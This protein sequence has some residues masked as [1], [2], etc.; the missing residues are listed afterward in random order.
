LSPT[1]GTDYIQKEEYLFSNPNNGVFAQSSPAFGLIPTFGGLSQNQ[2][3]KRLSQINSDHS[4]PRK[5]Y[6]VVIQEDPA[7]QLSPTFA[8]KRGLLN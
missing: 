3:E 5:L 1:R 8:A 6:P 4:E 2:N 7:E